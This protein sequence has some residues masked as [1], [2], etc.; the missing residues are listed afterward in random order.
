MSCEKL[1]ILIEKCMIIEM[2]CAIFISLANDNGGVLHFEVSIIF[3][4]K[5]TVVF[6]ICYYRSSY[7]FFFLSAHLTGMKWAGSFGTK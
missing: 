3:S 5:D 1:Q 4:A 6:F 2:N 7:F